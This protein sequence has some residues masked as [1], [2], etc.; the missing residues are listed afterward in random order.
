MDITALKAFLRDLWREGVELWLETNQLRFRG[1]KRVLTSEKISQLRENKPQIIRLLEDTPDAYLGFPLSHG[2]ASIFF[3]QSMMPASAAFHL[4]AMLKLKPGIDQDV[5]AKSFDWVLQR[6]APLRMAIRQLDGHLAQQVSYSLPSILRVET[7]DG[8]LDAW[9]DDHTGRA[10]DLAHDPLIRAIV[11]KKANEQVLLLVVHH[12]VADFWALSLF[13]DELSQVYQATSQGLEPEL[14]A[15]GKLYKDFVMEESTY[16]ASDAAEIDRQYWLSTLEERPASIQLH[17]VKQTTRPSDFSGEEFGVSLSNTLSDAIKQQAQDLGVSSFSWVLSCY[18]LLLY[19][20]SRETRFAIGVPMASRNTVDYQRVAGQFTNPVC[21]VAELGAHD[22]FADLANDVHSQ[23]NAALSHQ[24][25]PIQKII[26]A[27]NLPREGGQSGLFQFAFSWNQLPALSPDNPLIESVL[28]MKQQGA[29]YDLVLTG[30]DTSAGIQLQF[31]YQT[32]AYTQPVIA[33]FA[34]QLIHLLE[35]SVKQPTIKLAECQLADRDF[36]EAINRFHDKPGIGLMGR[37]HALVQQQPDALAFIEGKQSITYRQ[38]DERANQLAHWLAAQHVN[39]QDSVALHLPRSLDMVVSQLACLKMGAVSVP[40]DTKAPK[41]R[42][43]LIARIANC[44]LTLDAASVAQ[45]VH[46]ATAFDAVAEDLEST[47]CVLF[48]SGSTGVPKGVKIPRRAIARLGFDNG[49]LALSEG[50]RLAYASNVAFDAAN[51][52]LWNALLQGAA[53]VLIDDNTLLDAEQLAQTLVDQQVDALFITTALFHLYSSINPAVFSTLDTLMTGGEALASQLAERFVKAC[54]GTALINLYGPTENGTVSSFYPVTQHSNFTQPLPIGRPIYRS[55]LLIHNPYGQQN[56]T[57]MVGEIVVAGAGLSTGYIN[58]PEGAS[59]FF[60]QNGRMAYRTGDLGY[61]NDQGDIVYC[62]RKD[63]QLKIR[64]QRVELSEIEQCILHFDQIE[65]AVVMQQVEENS[66]AENAPL[67]AYFTADTAIDLAALRVHC[68]KHLLAVMQPKGFMQL[69]QLPMTNNGKVNKKALPKVVVERAA[70]VLPRS[71]TEKL[72]AAYF[73]QIFGVDNLTTAD[74]FFALGG[75]SLLAVKTAAWLSD[76][77]QKSLRLTDIFSNPSIAQLANCIDQREQRMNTAIEKVNASIPVMAG[78]QQK[79]LW[80]VQQHFKDSTAYNMPLRLSIQSPLTKTFVE[81]VLKKLISRHDALS[82][83]FQQVDSE[84]YWVQPLNEWSLEWADISGLEDNQKQDECKRL[85]SLNA[86]SRFNFETDYPIKAQLIKLAENDFRLAVCLHHVSVDGQSVGILLQELGTLL[87]GQALPDANTIQFRDYC[88]AEQMQKLPTSEVSLNFWQRYLAEHTG[89][90]PLATDFPRPSVPSFKGGNVS[91]QVPGRLTREIHAYVNQHHLRLS[92]VMMGLWALT[93]AK[94]TRE[95]DICIGF[96]VSGREDP[97]T[98]SMVGLFVNNLVMR[99]RFDASES[100]SEFFTRQQADFIA[101]FEHQQLPFDQMLNG[102]SLDAPEGWLPFLQASFQLEEVSLASQVNQWFDG[103]TNL[104]AQGVSAKYDINLR[105]VAEANQPIQLHFEYA[106]DLFTEATISKLATGFLTMLKGLTKAQ[107]I[108][109]LALAPFP[110]LP[111]SLPSFSAAQGTF[112]DAFTDQVKAHPTQVAVNY[113]GNQLSYQ[114][115]DDKSH[116]LA[117]A[118]VSHGVK[119][120]DYVGVCLQRSQ[121]LIVSLLAVWKAG[122]AYVPIDP[123]TPKDR[124]T[125]ILND[126]KV[127]VVVS[128]TSDETLTVIDPNAVAEYP[129]HPIGIAPSSSDIAYIIYTSGTTGN[130]KGCV[131]SHGNLLRLFETTDSLMTFSRDDHWCMFHSYAF[132]FSVWEVFGALYH[133]AKVSIIPKMLTQD[134]QAFYRFVAE[135]GITVLNQTPQAFA[136]FVAEDAK[137]QQNLAL[138]QVIFGGE[139]LEAHYLAD[140]I[141]R[142]PLDQVHLI[143]MYGITEVTVHASF[144][145]VTT[146]DIAQGDIP[147]GQPLPDMHW[148]LLDV[149]G[150]PTLTGAVGEIVIGGAGITQGYL[151]QPELT[152][153]KF[154][155]HPQHPDQRL[156]RSGDLAAVDANGDLRYLG[157]ADN[158]VSIRGFRIELGEIE[159]R[160]QQCLGIEEAKVVADSEKN[161]LIA[162]CRTGQFELNRQLIKQQ[163]REHLPVYMLPQ[164]FVSI[165]EWP[166]N[167]NGK[168]A[169]DRLP[170]AIAEDFVTQPYEAPRNETEHTL[171]T[172]WQEQLKLDKIGIHDNFFD[173][174]G[175]SLMALKISAAIESEWQCHVPLPKFF[176]QPTVAQLATVVLEETLLSQSLDDTDLMTLLEEIAE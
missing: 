82:Q 61:V 9:A 51:I 45:S 123:A 130:P 100:L 96:P 154:I 79:R 69:D 163:L 113:N 172:I 41:D 85:L 144:H 30:F 111:E 133:G 105:C 26:D 76:R 40:I 103:T 77:C 16:L 31:R 43:A 128:D 125:Y 68:R 110:V 52:E 145:R 135:Q 116:Q 29:I 138:R 36:I 38:L 102:L 5:L 50:K 114:Q 99:H 11:G 70:G 140:W 23:R 171:V 169:I 18:Q 24:M 49:F 83:G 164:A 53:L 14:P 122:A 2:Q 4:T 126:A 120:N 127:Q 22:T 101:L 112:L 161:L 8:S 175:H 65:M 158:Q 92:V 170:K 46:L 54:P 12:I 117:Q 58:P 150:K 107:V 28:S 37:Y 87:K 56:P 152:S 71:Q 15:I 39:A 156:Y 141:G 121:E 132:D 89:F 55:E 42:Q 143:N 98:L 21:F 63:D 119:P 148:M 139:K 57:G 60:M 165:D 73:E 176:E 137:Q 129:I 174:G 84:V 72:V 106:K 97:A 93:L 27:L 10:F 142:Y 108:N 17:G 94:L 48:T 75:H 115:L 149:H 20:Y 44:R 109:D 62:G 162:Y 3:Q 155:P 81:S 86:S 32:A 34:D 95:N 118:L 146:Q 74:D 33:A 151:N 25:Y 91:I 159:Q 153:A 7:I 80:M 47:A 160:L 136:A 19:W 173:L 131:V 157:R 67:V 147:I 90:L 88:Y 59:P 1:N 168:L 78:K 104:I 64:G 35:Q 13:I 66:A 134:T 166:I 167:H 124:Q 6:H